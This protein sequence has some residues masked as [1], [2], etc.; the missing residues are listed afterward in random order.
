MSRAEPPDALAAV[1]CGTNS[2]RLLVSNSKGRT[3]ERLMRITRLGEGVEANGSLTENAIERTVHALRVYRKVMEAHG[4]LRG[5]MVA[6]SAVRD[7]ANRERFLGAAERASGLTPELLSGEEEGRLSYMGATAELVPG[8]G[9]YLVVDVGGGSTELVLGPDAGG[10]DTLGVVSL[11]IGCVRLTER[12][13]RSDPPRGGELSRAEV[14]VRRMLEHADKV[15]PGLQRAAGLIGLA[16]TASTLAAMELGLDCY[17]SQ[18]IHHFVLT[19]DRVRA[20]VGAL[21]GED[22]ATRLRHPGLEEARADVIV[23]G[24]LVLA[25]VMEHLGF[26]SCLVSESDILDGLIMSQLGVGV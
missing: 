5:R 13:L 7:A 10:D 18:R 24:A 6:T 17:D 1:D 8:S 22:H 14:A 19:R 20:L 16:G 23:G 2:T 3:L 9:P 15:L 25:V 12:F 4:V 21:S 11:D 26:E